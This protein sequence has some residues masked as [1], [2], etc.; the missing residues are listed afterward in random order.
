MPIGNPETAI[1]E[2]VY[3]I[4]DDVDLQKSLAWTLASVKYSVEIF[5]SADDFLK[6]TDFHKA[7]CIVLD[8]LL[9]GITGLQLCR[10]FA[11]IKS[12]LAVV[13][14]SAHGDISSAV[15]C[16]RLGAVD[17]LEKPFGRE[18]LLQ[19]VNEGIV[20]SRQKHADMQEEEMV[21]Q[22]L[23]S[24][25][26]RERQVLDCMTE[27]LITK[28]IAKCLDLSPRTVDIHRSQIKQKLEL[29]SSAQIGRLMY[30][31]ERRRRRVRR[32]PGVD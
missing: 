14:I 21:S 32:G 15:R 31:E 9:P 22:R 10:H 2:C 28:E 20:R 4:E 16:L 13:L 23:A 24:L 12:P 8:L 26:Q 19:A 1:G 6:K 27:G 3:V 5:D 30:V 11:A 25:T 17:F 29:K 18:R 7:G